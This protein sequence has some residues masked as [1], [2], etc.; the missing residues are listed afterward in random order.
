M[1]VFA[2]V[3]SLICACV[4][5]YKIDFNSFTR[6]TVIFIGRLRPLLCICVFSLCISCATLQAVYSWGGLRMTKKQLYRIPLVQIFAFAA[7]IPAAHSQA[8][9][10]DVPDIRHLWVRHHWVSGSLHQ[11]IKFLRQSLTWWLWWAVSSSWLL[12][13]TMVF[14]L[15]PKSVMIARPLRVRSQSLVCDIKN[16]MFNWSNCQQE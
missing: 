5:H 13:L 10:P 7:D 8:V 6:E 14:I 2:T 1:L 15:K 16:L 3:W 11:I 4:A 12:I 9:S